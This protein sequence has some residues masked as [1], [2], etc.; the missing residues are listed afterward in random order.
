MAV[1]TGD[2]VISAEQVRA[3]LEAERPGV[4]LAIRR[5]GE[6]DERRLPGAVPVSL[7]RAAGM[8]GKQR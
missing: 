3:E 8:R 1:G 4:I 6:A 7:A 2:V 5:E